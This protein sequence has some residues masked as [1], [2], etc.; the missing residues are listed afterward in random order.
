[1]KSYLVALEGTPISW[2]AAYSAFHLAA[3]LGSRLIGLAARVP[4][5][6]RTAKQWLA[7]FE[8]G[9]RAAGIP[10]ES[11]LVIN[12]DADTLV[13]QADAADGVFLGQTGAGASDVLA[14]LMEALPSSLWLVPSQASVRRMAYLRSEPSPEEPS[15]HFAN[16]LSRRLGVDL[17]S[18]PLTDFGQVGGR[19]PMEHI[20]EW[21]RR[22][23]A[24]LL[25]LERGESALPLGELSLSPPCITVFLPPL[26]S[27]LGR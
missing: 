24:D 1:M 4:A 6:E 2:A 10:V 7:E 9:A 16:L 23:R 22:A 3:R 15:P 19:I 11:R 5:G 12:L 20:V 14:A 26:S 21:V 18:R 8:T 25:I 17:E 27:A 13:A